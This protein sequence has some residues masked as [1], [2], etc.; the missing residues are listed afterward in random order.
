LDL[1]LEEFFSYKNTLMK[2]LCTDAEIMRLL[3]VSGAKLPYGRVFP[4]ELV[5]EAVSEA[6][7]LICFDAD[8]ID[9]ENKTFLVPALYVWVFTHKSKMR[10]PEGGVRIDALASRVDKLLNGSRDFGLGELNLARVGRFSPNDDYQ[11]RVL[12]YR[13]RDFNRPHRR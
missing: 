1:N 8:V 10:L 7:T 2:A 9:A 6:Q 11:G 3:E 13:A 12:A 4:F 5:P